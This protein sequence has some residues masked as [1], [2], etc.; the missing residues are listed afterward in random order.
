[1]R[2]LAAIAALAILVGSPDAAA[3]SLARQ[4]SV[5]AG[6]I[7]IHAHTGPE[8]VGLSLRRS[9]DGIEAAR[10]AARHG[11]R[12]ILLK[13][14]YLETATQ[15]YYVSRVV[16]GIEV[17]GGIALNRTVGGLNPDAVEAMANVDG[18]LGRM[19]YMPTFQSAHYNPGDPE[20][21]P[22][23][24]NG[25]LLPEVLEVLDVVARYDLALST[26]HSSP[27]ESLTIVRAARAAGVTRIYVQHPTIEQIDMPLEMQMEAAR[28]GALLEYR[29]PSGMLTD[30]EVENVRALGPENVV[31]SSDRGQLGG[32]NHA[33]VFRQAVP[34]L[35]QAGFT[36]A[37]I[38]V[39][40][41]R[42]PARLLGID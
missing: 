7:D 30:E 19:V 15:A 31:L 36:Q 18:G 11:M 41:R 25:E 29:M 39:M 16:P 14:H 4:P 17:Y 5:V 24:R 37:E 35:L 1:M 38:D 32:P 40:T 8:V 27:E 21:V 26:G 10:L 20:A 13:N 9:I 6:M 2:S 33:D 28:L 42:N 23:S 22:V 3:Q 12:A 34:R